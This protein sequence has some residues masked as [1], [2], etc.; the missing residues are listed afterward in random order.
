MEEKK[1]MKTWM[2]DKLKLS[3]KERLQMDM[4]LTDKDP[5]PFGKYKGTPMGQ[6]EASYLDWLRDQ[7]WIGDWPTVKAYLDNNKKEIDHELKE[8][9]GRR[10]KRVEDDDDIGIFD[11]IDTPW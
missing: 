6:L 1:N 4:A 8:Q 9:G 11:D 10:R 2:A 3:V 7:K 5:M